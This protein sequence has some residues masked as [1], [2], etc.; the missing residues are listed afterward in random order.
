[1]SGLLAISLF[2]EAIDEAVGAESVWL[3]TLFLC[4]NKVTPG[5]VISSGIFERALFWGVGRMR[6]MPVEAD[7]NC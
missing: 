4:T 1:M 3:Q 5:L 7:V 2:R 6:A